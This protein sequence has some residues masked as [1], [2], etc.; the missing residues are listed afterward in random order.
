MTDDTGGMTVIWSHSSLKMGPF[1]HRPARM[2]LL[3]YADV[4]GGGRHLGAVQMTNLSE[5]GMGGVG[6]S[7][8]H[9]DTLQVQLSGIG[10]VDAKL[11]WI[12]GV[13]FGVKFDEKICVEAF[14][15]GGPN[16]G[17]Q[18]FTLTQATA[19]TGHQDDH[20]FPDIEGD[21]CFVRDDGGQI[22]INRR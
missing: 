11:I 1:P 21:G 10:Q 17:A 20:I 8:R 18:P 13:N 6:I 14:D 19:G 12:D 4:F 22:A 9:S 3:A 15:L 2:P 7:F 16:S 5:Y